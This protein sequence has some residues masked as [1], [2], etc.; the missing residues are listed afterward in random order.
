MT[1]VELG[2]LIYG[3]IITVYAMY[4]RMLE[5]PFLKERVEQE[6]EYARLLAEQMQNLVTQMQESANAIANRSENAQ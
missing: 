3:F 6:Y 4:V 2:L 1:D 5:V